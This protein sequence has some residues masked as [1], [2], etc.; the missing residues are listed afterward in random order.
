MNLPEVY[1]ASGDDSEVGELARQL[2]AQQHWYS[3][4]VDFDPRTGEA[5]PLGLDAIL[6][7][8]TADS[9]TSVTRDRLWRILSHCRASVARI[10]GSLSENPRRE[11][12]LLPIRDV[13]EVNAASFIAL[14]RRPGRNVREKLAGK[15]YMHAVRRYQSVDLPEN[16]LRQRV[17]DA[18]GRVARAKEGA[19][20]ARGRATRR[21]PPLA[22]LRRGARDLALGQPPSQQHLA[23]PP[24]LPTGL[25]RL[26]MASGGR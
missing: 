1:R 13:R 20:R 25:G 3:S 16:R 18:A 26:A 6:Q 7:R 2:L 10:L 15:P 17:P 12:A 24:G 14:S 19:P 4:I 9:D 21:H 8:L 23:R 22:S 11:Q 5:L